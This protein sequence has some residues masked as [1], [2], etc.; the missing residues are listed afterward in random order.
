[1]S[2]SAFGADGLL[3]YYRQPALRGEA[4]VF[5]SEGDLW[6]VSASGGTAQ[7]LTTHLERE[8]FPVLSPDGSKI[9]FTASYDGP[10]E[11]Y[12]MPSAGGKPER[13]TYEGVSGSR[14]PR[15]VS[16]KSASELVYAT[17]YYARRDAHQLAIVDLEDGKKTVIPLEQASDG[18]FGPEGETLYFT[19]LPR[20]RSFA[21]RYQ[22]GLIEN[23]WSYRA[24]DEEAVPLT[25]DFEGTSRNPMVWNKRLYFA[26]DRD[27]TMNLWSMTLQGKDL[28][29]HTTF[30]GWDVLSPSMDD[31]RIVFQNQADLWIYHVRKDRAEKLDLRVASD[32][33]QTRERWVSNALD[34]LKSYSLSN[35][36]K[37][38]ALTVRGRGFVVPVK[39][40][41]VVRIPQKAASRSRNL[42]FLPQSNDVIFRSD[43]SGEVEFW[44]HAANGLGESTQVTR[45]GTTMRHS[46]IPSPNG[47]LLAH[48]D[49][50]QVLWMRD[51]ASGE[52]REVARSAEG[53]EWDYID[54]TW[55]PDSRWVAYVD[56]AANQTQRIF[57][58]DTK[59]QAAP[60]P[61][62][63][64]R[65]DS[66]SPTFGASGKWLYFLSDRTFR[67][68]QG[69][70]WG[71]RQPEALLDKTTGIFMLDLVGGQRS[72]FQVYDELNPPPKTTSKKSSTTPT[73]TKKPVEVTLEGLEHRLHVAPVES[74]NYRSLS[75]AKG[76]L[77][78][79]YSRLE[80]G[81]DWHFVTIPITRD[82]DR[83]KWTTVVSD[84]RGFEISGDGTTCLV[85]KGNDFHV[86]PANGKVPS[87]FSKSKVSLSGLA[88]NVSPADEW[89][90][91]FADAWRM[92]RDYFY[93]PEMHQVDW[94]GARRK[95]EA[96]LPRVTSRWELD[97]L[98]GQMVGELSAMHTDI[99]AGDIRDATDGSSLGYLG[100]QLSQGEEGYRIDHIYG[101]DPDYPT[102]LAPLSKAGVELEVGDVILSLDGVRA[103]SVFDL[104][105]LLRNKAG[106][107]VLL[108]SRRIGVAGSRKS[109]VVPL[110]VKGFRNLKTS[111]WEY[112][113]RLEIEEKGE[114]EIGYFHMRAMSA[115]N[116]AEF[117]KGY[118]PVFN[119]K[120]LV[121]DMRQNY[122]GNIDSWILGR[123]NR[124]RW[125]YWKSRTG[126]P[127]AN[128]Q[129]AFNGHMVVLIDAYT[130]SDGEAF[131]EGFRRLG[132]GPLIGTKTWGGGIWLRGAT[133]LVDGGMARSPETGVYAPSRNWI[134]EGT[135]V[136]PDI[137]VDNLPHQAFLGK[138]AQLEAAIAYLQQKIKEDPPRNPEAPDRPDKSF[139]YPVSKK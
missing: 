40:G 102:E 105:I 131:S 43:Q 114:G 127:S 76:H 48:T 134:I 22:G 109:I 32:F 94:E 63:T 118:Y 139:R 46:G 110:S 21:K 96:L 36:G 5:H 65:L 74:S 104:G 59:G 51:L 80:L 91:M 17:W 136:K 3:G 49:R 16:W 6:K 125:M 122:G 123:L 90:Q 4:L 13:V 81:R 28:K 62:T 130:I 30:S 117:V 107:K 72:P 83:Q 52:E 115:S 137:R 12:I 56:L 119:R 70:P 25:A 29:Q 103:L 11:I 38:I 89:R 9:A 42:W 69:S 98:I 14:G 10:H 34:Y 77:Y 23:L 68:V 64:D 92:H 78:C 7:R 50:N 1:M 39:P 47:K 101:T 106:R 135:G 33:D 53:N 100:A 113:R 67:S 111:H 71:A 84:V 126:R 8:R 99:W 108:E 87:S 15:P 31:G 57:L 88:I 73:K 20:Q 93:D 66:Y 97:D 121:I 128:M 86:F 24:G 37:K 55:S 26:T 19:R 44:R 124:K 79:L 116:Y 95:H 35:D 75:V 133:R 60:V 27:G 132:L 112:T 54:L 18:Q 85:R 120:G 45:K 2:L 58:Y 61:I 41:R 129:Y 82:R 138:D